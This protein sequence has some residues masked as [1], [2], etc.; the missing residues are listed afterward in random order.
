MM[1][2]N[3]VGLGRVSVGKRS[4]LLALAWGPLFVF[5]AIP[6]ALN[7]DLVW[8]FPLAIM[9]HVVRNPSRG[10]ALWGWCIYGGLTAM[11]ILSSRPRAALSS[12]TM[13]CLL[14]TINL[15][16]WIHSLFSKW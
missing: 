16:V 8:C 14:L 11:V 13:L 12:F 9:S 2:S 7:R 10:E 15:V 3:M 6:N 5:A 4:G 1:N